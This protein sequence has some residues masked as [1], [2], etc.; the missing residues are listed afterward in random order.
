M[1]INIYRDHC[2]TNMHLHLLRCRIVYVTVRQEESVRHLTLFHGERVGHVL[3][4][5]P[6]R[7]KSLQF[8]TLLEGG[9]RRNQ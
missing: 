1:T 5:A 4:Q 9:R 7:Q 8:S 3:A 2:T 6:S